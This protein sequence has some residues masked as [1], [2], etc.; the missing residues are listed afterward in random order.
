MNY[1]VYLV[2]V[3]GQ[4]VLTLGDIISQAALEESLPVSAYPSKGMAQRGGF[5]KAQVRL[6]R[7]PVGPIIPEKGADLVIAMERSEALKAVPMVK[8]GGD[9]VLF[10]YAWLPTAVSLGRAN[11]PSLE[12]VTDQ[13]Q[14]AGAKLHVLLPD[15]R[16]SYNGLPVAGNVFV[17][18]YALR[19]ALLGK[20]LKAE[21]VKSII[22]GRWKRAVDQNVLAFDAGMGISSDGN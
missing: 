17:L 20:L 2:G 3:G 15:D 11:Y 7:Q 8:P 19:P 9:Y 14:Q 21:S 10:A 4:G 13:V 6:G 12:Q 1:D 22:R 5:V 16:P 18:G